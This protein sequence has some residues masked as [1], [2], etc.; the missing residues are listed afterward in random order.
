MTTST[1]HITLPAHTPLLGDPFDAVSAC[2]EQTVDMQSLLSLFGEMVRAEQLAAS[3]S[4]T[5]RASA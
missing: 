1:I 5:D 2:M 3:A 4:E